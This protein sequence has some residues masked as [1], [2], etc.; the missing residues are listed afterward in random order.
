MAP[1]HH[2]DLVAIRRTG[3]V[4]NGAAGE[5]LDLEA[6]PVPDDA[7]PADHGARPASGERRQVPVTGDEIAD[8]FV[9][10]GLRDRRQ[11]LVVQRRH[12]TDARRQ[13]LALAGV[14][15]PAVL[16]QDQP[17]GPRLLEHLRRPDHPP[18]RVVPAEDRHEHAVVGADVLEAAEDAGRDVEDVAFL[19]HDLARCPPAPP[20]EAPAALEDEEDL[21]RAVQV[22]GVP[23][24]RRLA[25]GAD[26][27][28]GRLPDVD[29]LVGALRDAGSDD[30]EVLLPVGA[31]GMGVDECATTRNQL[32]VADDPSIHFG[33]RQFTSSVDSRG[34]ASGRRGRSLAGPDRLDRITWE[35]A[36]IVI[37]PGAGL[38]R[39]GLPPAGLH[40]RFRRR[41]PHG[42]PG[43]SG[44]STYN[45]TRD[46]ERG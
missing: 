27:E 25:G 14:V 32:A 10:A 8:H 39:S 40:G 6:G 17:V 36:G 34:C 31:G 11:R 20:E 5:E 7:L 24:P 26:V 44:R 19:Q 35:Y 29:V 1:H 46:M 3:P 38:G 2:Q 9:R 4:R 28:P 33:G 22:Q 16:S 30:G 23:A 13:G 43:I 41:S 15:E 12:R 42:S 37:R 21:G 18:A 45:A